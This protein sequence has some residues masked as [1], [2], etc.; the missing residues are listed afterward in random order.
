M[1]QARVLLG[2]VDD[3]AATLILSGSLAGVQLTAEHRARLNQARDTVKQRPVRI[4][5]D[6]VISNNVPGAVQAHVD[7]LRQSGAAN[8]FWAEGWQVVMADLRQVCGIQPLIYVDHAAERVAAVDPN[9]TGEL[10]R[11]T[12]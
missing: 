12:L 8:G 7:T 4:E 11:V 9:D 1:R 3:N 2:W 5:P 6:N 10:A